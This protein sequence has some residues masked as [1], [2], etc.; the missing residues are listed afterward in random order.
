MALDTTSGPH[1]QSKA[2]IEAIPYFARRH[3]RHA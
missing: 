1:Q 3:R 2:L